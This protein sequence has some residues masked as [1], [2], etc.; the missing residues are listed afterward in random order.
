MNRIPLYPDGKARLL[1]RGTQQ[2]GAGA[3]IELPAMPRTGDDGAGKATLADGASLMRT[4]SV[5]RVENAVDIRDCYDAVSS[6]ALQRSA[7]RAFSERR[8]GD[9]LTHDGVSSDEVQ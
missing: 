9:P 7:G 4:D 5:D 2:A 6:H 1:E 3:D 8:D